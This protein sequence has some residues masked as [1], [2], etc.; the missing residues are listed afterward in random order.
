MKSSDGESF[1]AEL[2]AV[3]V[4]NYKNETESYTIIV[5]KKEEPSLETKE[6]VNEVFIEKPVENT[7]A[8]VTSGYSEKVEPSF[9]SGLFHE[10]L[11]PINVI[12]GFVQDLTDSISNLTPEQKES[13]DII[14]QN[15]ERLLNTMNGVI[16]YSNIQKNNI[17]LNISTVAA[18]EIIEELQSNIKQIT[19]PKEI[20]FAYGK[21]SSS[22]KF[23]TDRERFQNLISLLVKFAVGLTREKKIY[24]SAYPKNENEFIVSIKDNY[25]HATKY[26]F[27][28][29]K[30]GFLGE[31]FDS[32]EFGI[33]RLSLELAKAILRILNGKAE[34][35][36]VD[37]N[38]DL[39]FIFPIEFRKNEKP[40]PVKVEINDGK[41]EQAIEELT[42]ESA[43]EVK[44][45]LNTIEEELKE[46]EADQAEEA[47]SET[48][49]E[50]D[51][52]QEAVSETELEDDQEQETASD[53]ELEA[54]QELAS[55]FEAIVD[56]IKNEE[57]TDS[58]VSGDTPIKIDLSKLRCLYIEDQV[59]SQILFKVQMKE[60]KEIKFAVSFEEALPLLDSDSFD[61]IVMDIN[62][63]GEYNG[64][65][66][67]KLIRKMP[68]HENVPIIAVTAYVLPGDKEKFIAT[69]F[70]EFISKPIFKEKMLYSLM[71]IFSAE[72]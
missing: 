62:L 17:D 8:T 53:T 25:D 50:T 12:L 18:T 7:F 71:K 5:K 24:F 19:G 4:L 56:E 69:G 10:I 52:A 57:E 51:Q 23:K 35:S 9:L 42:D 34:I 3:P 13:A 54:E 58:S 37:N 33:S 39:F 60:L 2:T 14:N 44:Q 64:L 1:E 63:Q 26:L 41:I 32:K 46:L 30:N 67:L 28:F 70:S 16:E 29:Y 38:E 45:D 59:D 72:M 61:F 43:S 65:D 36:V 48:E 22:L 6:V 27:E 20:E 49:L 15:R 11:T 21:I 40:E 66:A 47:V 31:K 55:D 68:T